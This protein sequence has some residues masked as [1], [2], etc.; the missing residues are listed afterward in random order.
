MQA[1]R[2]YVRT[3]TW[4]FPCCRR[5]NADNFSYVVFYAQPALSLINMLTFFDSASCIKNGV[6]G[7]LIKRHINTL[8]VGGIPG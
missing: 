4:S 7:G 6:F 3:R 2:L 8:D 1:V 5:L